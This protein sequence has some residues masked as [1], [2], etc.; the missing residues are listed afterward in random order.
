MIF[1]SLRHTN[2]RAGQLLKLCKKDMKTA[3]TDKTGNLIGDGSWNIDPTVYNFC[4]YPQISNTISESES[5]ETTYVRYF[6]NENGKS[7]TVR[8]SWHENNATKFGD[9][10]NG[11]A[12]S[13][14]EVLF[15]LG[16]KNRF[17]VPYTY[18]SIWTRMVSKKEIDKYE[19]INLT[20]KELYALGKNSDLSAFTGKLAKDSNFL[21]LGDKVTEQVSTKTNILGGGVQL[22]KYIYE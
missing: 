21:I 10:L 18:L 9:Q 3:K 7:I 15:H 16:L 8:F 14:N 20:I 5:T 1:I 4:N 11:F 22:G 13:E 6:N 12:T 2:N 17:F 19:M